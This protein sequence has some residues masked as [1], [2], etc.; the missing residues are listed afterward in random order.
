M[1]SLFRPIY[2][3]LCFTLREN[4]GISARKTVF[5]CFFVSNF[6][7]G[8]W[9]N[10]ICSLGQPTIFSKL[11]LYYV[12]LLETHLQAPPLHLKRE[13]RHTSSKTVFLCFFVSKFINFRFLSLVKADLEP[14]AAHNILRTSSLLC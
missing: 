7:F 8:H 3:H 2:K 1:L 13:R 6:D 14:R 5:F 11:L 9:Q 10:P 4:G 12:N